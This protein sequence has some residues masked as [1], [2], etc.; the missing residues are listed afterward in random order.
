GCC[1]NTDQPAACSL[2]HAYDRPSLRSCLFLPVTFALAEHHAAGAGDAEFE[3]LRDPPG[4][5]D[6]M[7][8]SVR[9]TDLAG[10]LF[11]QSKPTVEMT[12]VD[13]Q[14]KMPG[15][16]RAV[17]APGHQGDRRPECAHLRQM[18][19]PIRDPRLEDRSEHGIGAY[20]GV[21]AVYEALDH[22][23]VDARARH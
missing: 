5:L 15:H 14:W 22:R 2:P 9:R 1:R 13:R 23:L 10:G 3:A 20:L 17:I 11:E 4:T 16:R 12:A 19:T 18:R 8:R 21:E 6:E 7:G